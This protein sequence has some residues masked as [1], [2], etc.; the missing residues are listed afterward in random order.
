MPEPKGYAVQDDPPSPY[1]STQPGNKDYGLDLQHFVQ[2]LKEDRKGT[3]TG[4]IIYK[5]T[6]NS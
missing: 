1:E 3:G 6:I 4:M 5:Q 2:T